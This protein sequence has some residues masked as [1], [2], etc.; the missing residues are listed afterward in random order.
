MPCLL[1]TSRV[2]NHS[3]Y[4]LYGFSFKKE[5]TKAKSKLL[6]HT[7]WQEGW[8]IPK[9]IKE[10]NLDNNDILTTNFCSKCK[11]YKIQPFCSD[12]QK[13]GE[14]Q[15]CSNCGNDSSLST[16]NVNEGVTESQLNEIY[17]IMDVYCHP[18][19]SGGQEIPIQ[20]AKLC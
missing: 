6:L 16:S 9:L 1:P 10:K 14:K 15:P 11:T 2:S 3:L 8:D 7:N 20:E 17:N 19:T 12:S 13:K 18:F 5:N 4:V